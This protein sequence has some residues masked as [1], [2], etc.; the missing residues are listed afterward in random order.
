MQGVGFRKSLVTLCQVTSSCPDQGAFWA[1]K[2]C[3]QDAPQEGPIVRASL[4]KL[5]PAVCTD[6]KYFQFRARRGHWE[7][8][9]LQNLLGRQGK[10]LELP[11]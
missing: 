10:K 6:N 1:L 5:N 3:G 9:K 4:W 11:G 7:S 2:V 8:E